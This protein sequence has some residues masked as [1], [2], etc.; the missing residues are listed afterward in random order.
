LAVFL[1]GSGGALSALASAE[2]S[3]SREVR[4]LAGKWLRYL[5]PGAEVKALVAGGGT[6]GLFAAGTAQGSVYI[7][8]DGGRSW[9]APSS[10]PSFPGTT[11]SALAF[12]P[13][14]SKVVW[15]A[16]TGVVR[17]GLLARSDDGGRSWAEIRKWPLRAAARALAVGVVGGRRVVAVGGD[18][19]VE[20]SLDDGATWRS[21][22][23][24]LDPGSGISFLRFH[25]GRPELLFAGSFRHPFVSDDLGGTWRRIAGGMIEDTEV[26]DIDFSESAPDDLWA[27]TCGWVYRSLDRGG[28]WVRYKEG[29]L[30]RRTHV[31]RRDPRERNRVLA[32]T[33]GGLF[34]S[35]DEGK[36]FR[37]I[38]PEMVVTGL[39]FDSVDPSLLLIGTEAEGI[40]RSLDGGRSFVESN[41][42]LSESRIS[43]AVSRG[44]GQVVVARVADGASGGL[45]R[46]DL[47][48]GASAR[49]SF[50]PPATIVALTHWR[51][52]LLAATADG[53][54][55]AEGESPFRQLLPGSMRGL[56]VVD[57]KIFV[58]KGEEVLVSADGGGTWTGAGSLSNRIDL[59][60]R[61]NVPGKGGVIA[62]KAGGR[63]WYLGRS[64][65]E[66]DAVAAG[67]GGRLLRGGF[68]RTAN[69]APSAAAFPLGVWLDDEGG[70]LLFQSEEQ[71][72][73]P[74]ETL[75]LPLPEKGLKVA[76]YSG[77]P[78]S[79]EGLFLATVGR[80]L[81]R[82]VLRAEAEAGR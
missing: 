40:L 10:G 79:A 48:S 32:G 26:F 8:T 80:G 63:T 15:A 60:F 70:R 50:S 19:G 52:K 20:V 9:S 56:L 76:G 30:D 33:T 75:S 65:W 51:K 54:F 11:V 67:N 37:R 64:G 18:G 42:G 72:A 81:F 38:G 25:P 5:L 66:E 82:F 46:V 3:P 36:T 2:A 45:W 69:A 39:A 53:L 61:A 55:A 16:L 74:G 28:V 12:D 71:G 59:L 34:E 77:D 13:S 49:L 6:P 29:L 44:K 4:P 35:L 47:E 17:G 78:R 22:F 58:A 68:G 23:P 1:G 14:S 73:S 21:S 62:A 27:A 41:Q 43:A 24:P 31:V 57:G 7:S